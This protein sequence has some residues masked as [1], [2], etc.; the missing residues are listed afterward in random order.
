MRERAA[1]LRAWAARHDSETISPATTSWRSAPWPVP[2]RQQVGSRHVARALRH[3]PGPPGAAVDLILE[4][5]N[6]RPGGHHASRQARRRPSTRSSCPASFPGS[7]CGRDTALATS[8][9]A[10]R[11]R[12]EA[13]GR[14]DFEGAYEL[15]TDDAQLAAR[16]L[17]TRSCGR[18][19]S[20]RT[21]PASLS[22]RTGYSTRAPGWTPD[23]IEYWLDYLCALLDRIPPGVL[24]RARRRNGLATA[25]VS[26]KPTGAG[27]HPD[28]ILTRW[29][30]I[31]VGADMLRRKG[32]GER[33][34]VTDGAEAPMP[35]PAWTRPLDHDSRGM[36]WLRRGRV[37]TCGV[38]AV[39]FRRSRINLS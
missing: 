12:D 34:G 18:G 1:A 30:L 28:A 15:Q 13:V 21:H 8:A 10:V 6:T 3:L 33:C 26:K 38:R 37:P 32:E 35:R 5:I 36:P 7:K 29:R 9:R 14:G 23:R 20:R 22:S 17:C 25:V 39:G 16:D 4:D 31:L 11:D 24:E 19:C 27:N 2:A